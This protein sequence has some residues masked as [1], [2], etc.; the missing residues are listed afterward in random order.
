MFPKLF[1]FLM[2]KSKFGKFFSFILK[3][4]LKI[5]DYNWQIFNRHFSALDSSKLI[6]EMHAA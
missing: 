2:L 3:F 1:N 6:E 4:R 5:K